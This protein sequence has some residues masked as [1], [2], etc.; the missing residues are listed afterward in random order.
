MIIKQSA[1]YIKDFDLSEDTILDVVKINS[2]HLTKK[3]LRVKSEK[4]T[5]YGIDFSNSDEELE[6]GMVIYQ[7]D[8]KL[9]VLETIPEDVIVI[10]PKDI[11][12]MGIIAHLLGNSHKPIEVEDGEIILQ[13]DSVIVDILKNLKIDFAVE[14]RS[15]KRALRH[16][17]FAHAH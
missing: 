14:K 2:D 12:D 11:N 8:D 6:S 7:D 1:G 5:T 16:A 10:V 13:Y 15:L 4:G 17:N 3:I 9:V